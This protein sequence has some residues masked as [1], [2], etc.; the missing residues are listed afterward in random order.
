MPQHVVWK[1]EGCISFRPCPVLG[2]QRT[3]RFRAVRSAYDPKRTSAMGL[4]CD[5]G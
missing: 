1:F 4:V 3:S 5:R 2:G